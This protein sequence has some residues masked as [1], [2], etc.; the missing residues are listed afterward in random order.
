MCRCG[1]VIECGNR[2]Q[3]TSA[4]DGYNAVVFAV[5]VKEVVALEHIGLNV[6]SA[7][8]SSLL[9]NCGERFECATLNVGVGDGCESD[10]QSQAVVGTESGV[11]G[12]DP[13]AVDNSLYRVV[14]EV[15]VRIGSFFS[16][17]IHVP[18]ENDFLGIFEA[19]CR[20]TEYGYVANLVDFV[21][22]AVFL[23]ERY[24]PVADF[25]EVSR[26]TW[27]LSNLVKNLPHS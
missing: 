25:V 3:T 23:S 12:A 6:G 1:L 15:V 20:R 10:G 7:G 24:E 9:V 26:W 11:V 14:V 17:H 27:H 22:E 21:F 16:Y 2:N 18:L 13:F 19:R 5:E 4:A 8:E